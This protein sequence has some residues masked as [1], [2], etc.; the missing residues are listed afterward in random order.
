ML[1]RRCL[2]L[3]DSKS[4][5]ST[6]L[7]RRT[8]TRVSSGW[9]ESISIL[10]IDQSLDCKRPRRRPASPW[11]RMRTAG[12]GGLGV[13]EWRGAHGAKPEHLAWTEL[14]PRCDGVVLINR[15]AFDTGSQHDLWP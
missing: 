12:W 5:S 15:C 1:P 13:T 11:G 2:R 14:A 8:T 7:P 3:A 4:N 9:V 6:R 10:F